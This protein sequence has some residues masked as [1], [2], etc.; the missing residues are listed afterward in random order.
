V[1]ED[2]D[3]RPLEFADQVGRRRDVQDVVVAELLSLE[4][5]VVVVERAVEGRFWWGFSP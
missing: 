2:R 5:L 1:L 4:L 3:R